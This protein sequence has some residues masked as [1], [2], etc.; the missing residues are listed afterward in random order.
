[1]EKEYILCAAIHYKDGKQYKHQPKNIATG[2]VVCGRRHHNII[3][4]LA[5]AFNY[6]T[7]LDT[8]QGFITSSDRFVDRYEGWEIAK[9][10][11]Q[12]KFGK[13]ASDKGEGSMLIS[14]N[15]Y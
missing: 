2:F 15:L 8:V 6:P 12:I 3:G 14:E 1:M 5:M 11:D 10:S 7:K 13:V 4:T 9:D